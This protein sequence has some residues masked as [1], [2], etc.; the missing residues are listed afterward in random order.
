LVFEFSELLVLLICDDVQIPI[1]S[2]INKKCPWFTTELCTLFADELISLLAF[3]VYE[4]YLLHWYRESSQIIPKPKIDITSLDDWWP[5]T[6]INNNYNTFCWLRVY[7]DSW[8]A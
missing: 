4:I 7:V 1:K 6:L 2:L 3:S 8:D 5:I